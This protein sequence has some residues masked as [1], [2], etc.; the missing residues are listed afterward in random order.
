V[1]QLLILMLAVAS[2]LAGC[3]KKQE[4]PPVTSE[5]LRPAPPAPAP[6]PAAPA[7]DAVPPPPPEPDATQPQPD[8]GAPAPSPDGEP[9]ATT[10]VSTTAQ[11]PELTALN[12]ALSKY[13]TDEASP[14]PNLEALVRKKYLPA[15]P[16]A[17]PGKQFFYNMSRMQVQLIDK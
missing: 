13:W 14:P 1:K 16:A 8:P 6:P 7:T 2:I 4:I 9:A 11:S 12:K 3:Q 17:P 10:A 15:I 5:P